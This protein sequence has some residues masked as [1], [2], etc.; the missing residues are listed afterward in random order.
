MRFTLRCPATAGRAQNP[1]FHARPIWASNLCC[2]AEGKSGA[3]RQAWN[4]VVRCT[5]A[6]PAAA[7]AAVCHTEIVRL[8]AQR[9]DARHLL[10]SPLNKRWHF[11]GPESFNDHNCRTDGGGVFHDQ[12]GVEPRPGKSLE[13]V[14]RRTTESVE[15]LQPRNTREQTADTLVQQ[16]LFP[17]KAPPLLSCC[18]SKYSFFFYFFNLSSCLSSVTQ[19][20]MVQVMLPRQLVQ[21]V[22]Q[23]GGGAGGADW[24]WSL[25]YNIKNGFREATLRAFALNILIILVLCMS[26]VSSSL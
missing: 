21:V 24:F 1:R 15:H 18:K 11:R 7:A 2:Y 3:N 4:H 10:P 26:N 22:L 9:C 8:S 25:W 16:R 19:Y 6:S 13:K 17:K 5:V 12:S 23:A 14:F 20:R